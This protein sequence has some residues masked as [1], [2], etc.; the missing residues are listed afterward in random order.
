MAKRAEDLS[1]FAQFASRLAD[2][3]RAETLPRFR[4]GARA[5]N[6]S[7]AAFDPVTDA[8]REAER[9]LRR[10][11]RESFP[12][13]GVIG[14]EFGEENAG[15]EWRWVIDPVDGTRAFCCGAPSWATLIALER[16]GAPVIGVIDQPFT[17][18]RWTGWGGASAH[19]RGAERR[20]CRVSGAR[21]LA[22]A[23]VSTTDPRA[24]GYF[25]GEEAEAFLR[26][27]HAARLARFSLDAYAYG[28]LALGE[29]DLVAEASLKR[30]DYAALVPVIEG[31]GGVITGWEGEPL[32]QDPRGRVLA[33]ASPALHAEAVAFLSR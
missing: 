30:H 2:A 21:R 28:L 1:E 22:E 12:A 33:A 4:A 31:A 16:K 11:I 18:E 32:G 10:L 26:L 9:A 20:A 8:D 23:R 29:I 24:G 5:D 25:T 15:A 17:G 14:E 7:K 6:K 19:Q 13:H 27:T 3:A